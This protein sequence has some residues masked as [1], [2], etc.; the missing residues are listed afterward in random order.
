MQKTMPCIHFI[1]LLSIL[2][3]A[4]EGFC[5]VQESKNNKLFKYSGIDP[6]SYSIVLSRNDRFWN[7]KVGGEYTVTF[8]R[9]DKL[10]IRSSA[11]GFVNLHDFTRKQAFS[12][13][14]WR[15][16][17]GITTFLELKELSW[18]SQGDELIFELGLAH[19]SHHITDQLGYER[20]FLKDAKRIK[21]YHQTNS[22]EYLKTSF[23]FIHPSSN[24]RYVWMGRVGL[25]YFPK[26]FLWGVNRQ[27]LNSYF[28]EFMGS[29]KFYRSVSW[30]TSLYYELIN[31]D[32]NLDDGIYYSSM[33]DEALNFLI[34]ESGLSHINEKN[35]TFT[36][37]L[38]YINS[39][40]RG[41]DFNRYYKGF[42]WGIRIKL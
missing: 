3:I 17:M 9:S 22:F 15:G 28:F 40:G 34:I 5:Q 20:S 21:F 36:V 37:F 10:T 27:L 7:N 14:M 25:K 26:P 18:M 2:L 4:A 35:Q 31:N 16:N 33:N 19:E 23:R 8:S 6:D 42:G 32:Y 24:L 39:D 11:G 12:W 13:Q 41:I 30:F 1:L 29:F 38:N